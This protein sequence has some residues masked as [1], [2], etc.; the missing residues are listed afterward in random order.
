M[1]FPYN[2]SIIFFS[3]F[4]IVPEFI[5]EYGKQN[6]SCVKLTMLVYG[7]YSDIF[8]VNNCGMLTVYPGRPS[9]I[10]SFN[11]DCIY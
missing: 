6:Y 3:S 1:F 11:S 5:L 4:L 2:F 10:S 7:I 9:S 8:K